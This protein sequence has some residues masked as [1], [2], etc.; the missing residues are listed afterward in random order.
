MAH[1]RRRS[2]Q[3]GPMTGKSRALAGLVAIVGLATWG[4]ALTLAGDD[5]PLVPSTVELG[6]PPVTVAPA[7]PSGGA[8]AADDRPAGSDPTDRPD[9]APPTEDGEPGADV[10]E[11][12]PSS[13]RA[14]REDG[15]LRS[16]REVVVA[17]TPVRV[18]GD[19]VTPTSA[20]ASPTVDGPV[21]EPSAPSAPPPV[22]TP[23]TAPRSPEP[24]TP[25]ANPKPTP[26]PGPSAPDHDPA[27][28]GEAFHVADHDCELPDA[29]GL[30]RAAERTVG[31]PASPPPRG[32]PDGP[33]GGA[34]GPSQDSGE[35]GRDGGELKAV[36]EQDDDD[37]GRDE[38]G[39]G[40][41]GRGGR[42]A[43]GG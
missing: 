3:D 31:T 29:S 4:I 36:R 41:G 19:S 7:L 15:P 18:A 35:R 10:A 14:G 9:A 24:T 20:P 6:G 23:S 12:S 43:G 25:T 37:H 1:R 30:A 8:D 26:A 2:G 21:P 32:C 42:G 27:A 5:V 28:G 38:R 17:P 33:A 34:P 39:R 13:S 22:P 16:P 40:G 11:G